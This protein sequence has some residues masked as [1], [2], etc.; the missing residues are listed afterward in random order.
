MKA[1]YILILVL[2]GFIFPTFVFENKMDND[3]P[4]AFWLLL[5]T[6]KEVIPILF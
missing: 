4:F 6:K 5:G 1:K 3:R 2:F